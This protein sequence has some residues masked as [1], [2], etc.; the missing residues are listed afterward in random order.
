MTESIA[1][2]KN[3]SS[4]STLKISHSEFH[5]S[6][7]G[8]IYCYVTITS[9][10][11]P[12]VYYKRKNAKC[13]DKHNNYSVQKM[14][15]DIHWMCELNVRMK[16]YRRASSLSDADSHLFPNQNKS[17]SR[18]LSNECSFAQEYTGKNVRIGKEQLE[19][20]LREFSCNILSSSVCTFVCYL[21]PPSSLNMKFGIRRSEVNLY[22]LQNKCEVSV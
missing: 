6:L 10:L 17:C 14:C 18:I 20:N 1:F 4:I 3:L 13:D 16:L 7:S 15:P 11:T 12:P 19:G 8:Y 21:L 2:G 5:S 9:F 22:G